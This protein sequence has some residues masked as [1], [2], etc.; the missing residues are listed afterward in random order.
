MIFTREKLDWLELPKKQPAVQKSLD[1]LDI[2]TSKKT[3]FG[4]ML[5][6]IRAKKQEPKKVEEEKEPS[7]PSSPKDICSLIEHFKTLPKVYPTKPKKRKPK[8]TVMMIEKYA[9]RKKEREKAMSYVTRRRLRRVEFHC[10]TL[11]ELFLTNA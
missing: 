5:S 7:P 4:G 2:I 11:K 9:E 8:P 3:G 1:V 6:K 10:D